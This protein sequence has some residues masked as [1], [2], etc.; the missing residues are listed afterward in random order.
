MKQAI[1]VFYARFK[2][3][4]KWLRAST[5]LALTY[6]AYAVIIGLIAPAVIQSQAPKQLSQL[7]GRNVQLER[8]S[9]NPFL[10]RAR[11]ENFA[12]LEQNQQQA[13][14]QFALLEVKL[15]FGKAY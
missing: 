3:A 9:I 13:F 1:S 7:L 10:L 14:T 12:I 15:T 5:Y 2:S 6:V 8:V 4:P 11:I